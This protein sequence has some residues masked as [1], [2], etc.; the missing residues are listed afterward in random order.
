MNRDTKNMAGKMYTYDN[1]LDDMIR[2]ILIYN[3]QDYRINPIE[4]QESLE[5]P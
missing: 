3:K 1:K 5:I 4:I 2:K